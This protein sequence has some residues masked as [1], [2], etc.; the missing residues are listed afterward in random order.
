MLHPLTPRTDLLPRALTALGLALVGYAAPLNAQAAIDPSVAPRAAAMELSGARTAATEY[1]GRYLATA[2][3]DGQ[4]WFQLGLFYLR[5]ARDWHDRGHA[6]DPPGPLFLDFAA[7]AFDQALRLRVDSGAVLRDLVALESSLVRIEDSGWAVVHRPGA[8]QELPPLPAGLAELGRNLV[9]SCPDGGVLLT[10]SDVETV[11][12][13][14][15]L[16]DAM[17]R[18]DLLPVILA[19]YVS[20]SLYRRG[21]APALGVAPGSGAD[22]AIATVTRHRPV[23]LTPLADPA[24]SGNWSVVRLVRVSDPDAAPTS[25]LVTYTAFAELE[26]SGPSPWETDL[27]AVYA[28][29]AR[30]NQL[31]CQA[32][33]TLLEDRPFGACGR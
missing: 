11:A 23:C 26:R 30:H 29:A 14:T 22:E 32:I 18:P 6:G 17:N 2:P 4:A 13:W 10:G 1:L 31:I 12:V 3:D 27:R 16:L 9:G 20:D 15:T 7:T 21:M 5:D 8:E 19:R 33:A 24:P 28:A 25:D